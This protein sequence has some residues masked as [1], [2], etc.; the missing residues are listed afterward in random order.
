M[1]KRKLDTQ[2]ITSPILTAHNSYEGINT[3]F[4]L[5]TRQ[6]SSEVGSPLRFSHL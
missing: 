2:N 4:P 5:E 6:R 3:Y 1:L